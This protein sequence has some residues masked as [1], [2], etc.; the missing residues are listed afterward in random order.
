MRIH[1]GEKPYLCSQCDKSF[2]LNNLI[3]T[4]PFEFTPGSNPTVVHSVYEVVQKYS[5]AKA[6]QSS[7][8]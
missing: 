5:L 8:K 1:T 4:V 2:F 6:F 3:A 7:P